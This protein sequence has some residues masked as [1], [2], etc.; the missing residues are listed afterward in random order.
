MTTRLLAALT[1]SVSFD[2]LYDSVL[3]EAA[4]REDMVVR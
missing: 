3:Q 4:L 1:R 2:A